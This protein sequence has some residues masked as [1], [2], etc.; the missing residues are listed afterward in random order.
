MTHQTNFKSV[1]ILP[2]TFLPQISTMPSMLLK[3]KDG[4][5]NYVTDGKL[6]V[7]DEVIVGPSNAVIISEVIESRPARGEWDLPSYKGMNPTFNKVKILL[8]ET[9]PTNK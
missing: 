1:E 8:N 3:N 5:F 7:G 4:T 9:S 6:E 2:G